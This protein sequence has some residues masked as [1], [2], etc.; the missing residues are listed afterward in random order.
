MLLEPVSVG[1][2]DRTRTGQRPSR[3]SQEGL[4]QAVCGVASRGRLWPQLIGDDWCLE[5]HHYS[6]DNFD[7]YYPFEIGNR[8]FLPIIDHFL[9]GNRGSL[10]YSCD[11]SL[12]R[13]LYAQRPVDISLFLFCLFLNY[14]TLLYLCIYIRAA[15]MF[16]KRQLN[17][18]AVACWEITISRAR[19]FEYNGLNIENDQPSDIWVCVLA[20][21]LKEVTSDVAGP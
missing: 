2:P 11:Q 19:V 20:S 5:L 1:L 13:W 18:I 17:H 16:I 6:L 14:L 9:H 12:Q 21:S 10:N 3:A 8:S 4:L 7:F 15:F